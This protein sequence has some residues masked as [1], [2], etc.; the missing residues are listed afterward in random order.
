MSKGSDVM[1]VRRRVRAERPADLAEQLNTQKRKVDFDS[2]DITARELV[3]MASDSL[4]DVA[5]EYQRRFRWSQVRQSTFIESVFLGIPI[6]SLFMAAN[7]DGTWE[8]IDGVQRLSTLIHFA[9]DEG[10]RS[11]IG[12]DEPLKLTGLQK[13]DAFE[14]KVYDDLSKPIQLQFLLK[15]L[16]VTTISDKSDH[17]VRFDLFE[18]LN[19]GGIELTAQEIRSCIYRGEFNE[20]LRKLAQFAPFKDVVKMPHEAEQNG[21]REE[22]VLRFLAYLDRY[23]TFDHSVID[24]LNTFMEDASRNFDYEKKNRIFEGTFTALQDALPDGITR[25]RKTTPVNLYEAV[26]VGAALALQQ[27]GELV[28]VTPVW[29]TVKDYATRSRIVHLL[30]YAAGDR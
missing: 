17:Q 7:T 12:L 14:G 18:R 21:T 6:P 10:A 26:A 13:L 15:P 27:K 28:G 23:K 25:G 24:F 1:S 8:L 20:A 16:K 4:I 30:S 22:Y 3:G 5:P 19:T 11:R 2:Y 29:W 9:G